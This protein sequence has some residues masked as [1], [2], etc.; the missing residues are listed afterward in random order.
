MFR[1]WCFSASIFYFWGADARYHAGSTTL[2]QKFYVRSSAM[3]VTSIVEGSSS[4]PSN[5]GTSGHPEASEASQTNTSAVGLPMNE[6]EAAPQWVRA[7][8]AALHADMEEDDSLEYTASGAE[9][10]LSRPPMMPGFMSPPKQ[11]PGTASSKTPA[12]S[13][14]VQ[15][16]SMAASTPGTASRPRSSRKQHLHTKEDEL[17]REEEDSQMKKMLDDMML[18]DSGNASSRIA[19]P[20]PS[21]RANEGL[22]PADTAVMSPVGTSVSSIMGQSSAHELAHEGD[23]GDEVVYDRLDAFIFFYIMALIVCC[24][25]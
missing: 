4:L 9:A 18:Q 21:I 23:L 24:H 22:I 19:T 3:E 6:G 8:Q 2:Y 5:G 7:L 12:M 13:T 20:G 11:A 16:I 1:V 10:I 14:P 25:R 17:A 15:G